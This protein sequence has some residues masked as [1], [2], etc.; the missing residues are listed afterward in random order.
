VQEYDESEWVKLYGDDIDAD[1]A[2]ASFLA[3]RR[4]NLHLF[5][6]LS[7]AQ[8]QRTGTH[9]KR[10]DETLLM[11]LKLLAGHTINHLGQLEML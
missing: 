6:R 9:P 10:G 3:T 1:V 7:D 5:A 11:G 2:L 4:W 8:L